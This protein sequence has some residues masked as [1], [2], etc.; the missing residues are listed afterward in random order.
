MPRSIKETIED[1]AE[2]PDELVDHMPKWVSVLR[3][4]C[5]EALT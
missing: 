3:S 4:L 2:I 5:R 1:V